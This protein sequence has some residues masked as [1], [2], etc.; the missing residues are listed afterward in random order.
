MCASGNFIGRHANFKNEAPMN[1]VIAIA[2]ALTLLA[3]TDARAGDFRYSTW[4]MNMDEVK[5]TEKGNTLKDEGDD[6]LIYEG[7]L[8]GNKC[9]YAY[10]FLDGH[11]VSAKHLLT[12][13]HNKTKKHVEVFNKLVKRYTKKYGAPGLSDL[14]WKNYQYRGAPESRLKALQLGHVVYFAVWMSKGTDIVLRMEGDDY[15]I[16][17]TVYYESREHSDKENGE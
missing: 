10:I 16:S 1:K 2:A 14:L 7:T 15:L 4:G 11:L 6:F 8:L 17:T 3:F 13:Q 12:A 5:A 9:I